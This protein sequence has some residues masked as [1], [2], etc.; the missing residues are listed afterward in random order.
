MP[1]QYPRIAGQHAEYTEAQL[2]AFRAEE[3]A[4]DP[5]KMMRMVAVKMT[6]PEI[7]AVSD[8][9]AVLHCARS[10]VKKR[11]PKGRLFYC[12]A[13][14]FAARAWARGGGVALRRVRRQFDYP[15]IA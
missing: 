9:F 6:D 1:S 3:R 5:N 13:G 15:L 11:R 4:N 8:Y 10:G 12:A 14:L 7:K 2:R